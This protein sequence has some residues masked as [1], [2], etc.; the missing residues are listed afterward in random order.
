[1]AAT[2]LYQFMVSVY[3][4][5]RRGGASCARQRS[6]TTSR[7]KGI[8]R[9]LGHLLMSPP[10]VGD[11]SCGRA[12]SIAFASRRPSSSQR[13]RP[14]GNEHVL[15]TLYGR[16]GD[17]PSP[18]GCVLR[19]GR[20]HRIRVATAVLFALNAFCRRSM[21]FSMMRRRPPVAS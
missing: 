5:V 18:P 14:E 9:T 12:V 4:L 7:K 16:Y 2:Y 19:T 15:K 20:Q 17:A 13:T 11:A 21:S 1:M 10:D 8:L 6:L 3:C